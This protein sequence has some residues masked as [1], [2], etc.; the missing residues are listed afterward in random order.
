[1]LLTRVQADKLTSRV[2][3]NVGALSPQNRSHFQVAHALLQYLPTRPRDEC[4]VSRHRTCPPGPRKLRALSVIV[5]RHHGQASV[6]QTPPFSFG[7]GASNRAVWLLGQ[8][9]SRHQMSLKPTCSLLSLNVFSNFNFKWNQC[10]HFYC[11][12]PPH[13]AAV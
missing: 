4:P 12:W 3:C 11:C 8:G 13:V 2:T 1:M 7:Q 5:L 9:R 10:D 6:I